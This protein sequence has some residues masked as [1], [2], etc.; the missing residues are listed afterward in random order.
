MEIKRIIIG[1][2]NIVPMLFTVI[3]K[4]LKRQRK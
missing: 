1:D 2:S 4:T 3:E